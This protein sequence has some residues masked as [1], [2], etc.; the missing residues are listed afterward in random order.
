MP[1]CIT[2]IGWH[3]SGKTTL[4]VEIVGILK[5]RGWNVCVV[6]SSSHSGV[7]F[8]TPEKDSSRFKAAGADEVAFIAPDQ[9][10]VMKRNDNIPFRVLAH[11]FFP[12]ADIVLGEGFKNANGV[13][14]IEVARQGEEPTLYR[15]VSG[16][17]AVVT[18]ADVP[19][20]RVFRR[21][22]TMEIA[23]FIEKR[24]ILQ[25]LDRPSAHLLVNGRHIPLKFFVQQAIAGA[26]SGLVEALKGTQG[27]ETIEILVKTPYCR[28]NGK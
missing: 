23:E 2:F 9:V 10:V 6:K 24:Y 25:D 16:V 5:E 14:K 1:D 19:G 7:S 22:E 20:T 4:L 18:D 26:V 15:E 28:E 11:R 13:D 3:N 21:N 17:M 27:A 8:D 12:D